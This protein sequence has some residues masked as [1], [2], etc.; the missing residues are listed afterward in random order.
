MSGAHTTTIAREL[1]IR[2]AQVEAVVGLLNQQ[3]T[4]PFIARYRKE[5]TGSLDEVAVTAIRDRLKQLHDLDQRREAILKSLTERDL[6]TDELRNAIESATAM[7]ELEDIYLPYR[8]KRRT[9]ASIARER[10]LE[11]LAELILEQTDI[12]PLA[13]AKAYVNSGK[14]VLS[15]ED[16]LAGARD[17]IA[18]WISE[19]AHLRAELRRLFVETGVISS[20]VV[21]GKDTEGARFRDYFDWHEP[22]KQAPSHRLLAMRRGENEGV[23]RIHIAPEESEALTIL[24]TAWVDGTG[25]ASEQ[26]RMACQDS[27]KRLLAPSMETEVAAEAKERADAEAIR[28]FSK[29][30]RELLMAPPLGR[31]RVL[32]IDPGFRTGC[33]VVCLDKQGKLLEHTT[34][35]PH[36]G[37]KGCQDAEAE[38]KALCEKQQI[39][40]IA[41]GNGT[42]GRETELFIR[43]LAVLGKP[44]IEMVNEAGASV[45]SASEVAREEFPDLDL[46]VRGA[47]SIGR[48]LLDPLAEL[49][50][51][52]PKAIGV[53]QYQHDVDQAALRQSLEDTVMSCVNQVGVEV[54][55]SSR[56]L[57]AYVSGI[58]PALAQNIVRYR[59]ENG[60]F[61]S[62]KALQKVPRLG[63]KAFEQAAG[64][65]R[66]ADADNPLDRSAVHPE[67]YHVVEAMAV[68]LGCTVTQLMHDEQLRQ[69]IKL[70]DFVTEKT[71]LPTLKDIM[72]ELARPGR[73]PRPEFVPFSFDGSVNSIEDLK[74]GMTLPGV[75]TN[76]TAF[77]AF[78]D[79]GVHHD[80]LVHKSEMAERY[81]N[82]PNQVVRIHQR[83]TVRVLEVDTERKRISLSMRPSED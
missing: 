7:A 64:F 1:G 14:E 17:I 33:K 78:V 18:E 36:S 21:S 39:Q 12:D 11:P 3:A 80:G 25:L 40:V 56:H 43:D 9:R 74:V 52:D 10:G 26:V 55:T 8:P 81:V 41:V 76:V 68:R 13:E 46:T 83:V 34:I 82:D 63:P 4:V 61:K 24:E 75:I 38:I 28:V 51:I 47:I 23:L 54:N 35:F 29:N 50:K 60:P 27:Y 37:D 20:E 69:R 71:G 73:D 5:A 70:E 16:A 19:D 44:L 72:D 66:I 6:L 31:K 45:Y 59:D 32:A 48:R 58:G 79:V 62:R 2:T 77:G 22:I 57:L 49:I 15:P 65:L 30:L 53:G 67:S 42:A